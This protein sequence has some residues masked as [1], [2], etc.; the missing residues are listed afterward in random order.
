LIN[1]AQYQMDVMLQYPDCGISLCGFDVLQDGKK[2]KSDI[3]QQ[4]YCGW[5]VGYPSCWML[6]KSLLP[7]LPNLPGF[8]VPYEYDWDPYMLL[9]L[10]TQTKFLVLEEILEQYNLHPNNRSAQFENMEGRTIRQFR[11][12]RLVDFYKFQQPNLKPVIRI[13]QLPPKKQTIMIIGW[14]HPAR[15][16]GGLANAF[17][18]LGYNV[19]RVSMDNEPPQALPIKV[20]WHIQ[21][22]LSNSRALLYLQN[23]KKFPIK[24]A[25]NNFKPDWILL[26]QNTLLEYD[27]SDIKIP[28]YLIYHEGCW[29]RIFYTRNTQLTG[30]FWAFYHAREQLEEQWREELDAVKCEAFILHSADPTIYIDRE[31]HRD[32]LIGLKG[33]KEYN[34]PNR[35]LKYIYDDRK[36]FVIYLETHYPNL[37]V[38]EPRT[39]GEQFVEKYVDFMNRCV[40]ALNT[41]A[42]ADSYV[43]ERQFQALSMGCVL[44]Q[45]RYPEMISQ[46]GFVDYENCLLFEN[47]QELDL[48]VQW[49]LS[50]PNELQNIRKAGKQLLLERHTPRQRAE[51]ILWAIQ[52]P[53]SSIINP[54]RIQEDQILQQFDDIEQDRQLW[55]QW[56]KTGAGKK[57]GKFLNWKKRLCMTPEQ[58]KQ[59]ENKD[60][61][62]W[63]E[64]R[65]TECSKTPHKKFQVW[66]KERKT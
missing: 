36:R 28:I 26:V 1:R 62:L 35:W 18:Q 42:N 16:A 9:I 40:V 12:D 22:E 17:E 48:K 14:M 43:N 15:M 60:R 3:F 57:H 7:V 19:I 61:E 50:H 6:R 45:Q 44:L 56:Y 49:I 24:L 51:S 30:I 4:L 59:E 32:I 23:H 20:D 38:Y 34:S 55:C 25:V 39:N 2:I 65:K 41:C 11:F 29:D 10:Q 53:K 47:E 13:K 58:K 54:I 52:N 5:N 27:I 37:F 21:Q 8:E 63:K 46:Q 64:W 31:I 66:L 33:A